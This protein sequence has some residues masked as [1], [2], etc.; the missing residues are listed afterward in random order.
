MGEMKI[1]VDGGLSNTNGVGAA[2]T[3]VARIFEPV[4]TSKSDSLSLRRPG[5]LFGSPAPSPRSSGPGGLD[6]INDLPDDLLLLILARLGYVR[7]AAR[8]SVL[9]RRWCGLWTRLPTLVFRD[10]P[11]PSVESVLA[12]VVSSGSASAVSLL[13]IR[14][15]YRPFSAQAGEPCVRVSS[16][17][18]T[19][20]RLSPEQ[21][22]LA[23]PRGDDLYERVELPGFQRATTISLYSSVFVLPPATGELFPALTMLLLSGYASAAYSTLEDLVLR[24]PRL[25]LLRYTLPGGL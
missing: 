24:C 3:L 9:S 15:P 14:P 6:L 8:A 16:L 17:L 5:S 20:A 21:L 11:F 1:I 13:D 18:R 25:R 4:F 7:T 10:V 12:R 19:A 23:V 2:A 22:V